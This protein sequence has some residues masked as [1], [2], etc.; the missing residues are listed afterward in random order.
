M[1]SKYLL[2]E[3]NLTIQI[4][5]NIIEEMLL[6][7]RKY[8]PNEFGGL[9]IGF[10]NNE[11]RDLVITDILAPKS[12]KVSPVFFERETKD[13]HKEL[14][15]FYDS[16]PSKYYVGEWHSHPNGGT[17]PSGTDIKAMKLISE[18]EEVSINKPV[19]CIIGYTKHDFQLQ[20]HL[21]INN[22]IYTYEKN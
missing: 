9:L 16:N 21:I 19:L 6:S 3:K 2:K 13:L 20:F 1:S 5:D 12:F 4:Q 10:Y 8:Y 7:A 15:L 11:N 18:S 22:K 17:N 14:K